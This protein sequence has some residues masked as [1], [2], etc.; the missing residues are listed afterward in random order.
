MKILI[1]YTAHSMGH[2]KIAENIAYWVKEA[3]DE[4][5]LEEVLKSNPSPLVKKFLRL[6]IWTNQRFPKFWGFMYRYGFWVTMPFRLLV[7]WKFLPDFEKLLALHQPDIVITTQTS[8]SAVMSVAKKS[9]YKGKWLITFSDYHFHPY[10]VY[11]RAD[12]YLVNIEEQKQTLIQRG[13]SPEKILVMGMAVPPFTGEAR[14]VV[15]QK[16]GI[17]QTAKVILVNIGG[18]TL[19]LGV[20]DEL[21]LALSNLCQLASQDQK[22]LKVIFACG[23]DKAFFE[24]VQ[25]L[26]LERPEF[27]A[28]PFYPG[29]LEI[30]MS[31]DAT[32]GKA[33]GLTTA[34]ALFAGVTIFVASVLPGQEELNL[35]YLESKQLVVNLTAL[36]VESWALEIRARLFS[37]PSPKQAIMQGKSLVSRISADEIHAFLRA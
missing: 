37:D 2:Q 30:F 34:E 10:W 24:K 35:D 23:Y 16:L 20:S 31:V 5:V 14:E 27:L 19:G 25:K 9:S 6:H 21:M 29:L 11:P 36:P 8:A 26:S 32:V 15:R 17:T 28:L 13:Y 4:V 22:E 12:G 1:L 18:G 7:A 3:G 33:G